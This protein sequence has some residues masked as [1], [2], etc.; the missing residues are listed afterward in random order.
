MTGCGHETKK[1]TGWLRK[2]TRFRCGGCDTSLWFYNLCFYKETFINALGQ[3]R[4]VID[5]SSDLWDLDGM[6]PLS[7]IKPD[8][9]INWG[10]GSRSKRPALASKIAQYIANWA[11]IDMNL[12]QMLGFILQS[13]ERAALAIYSSLNNRSAQLRMVKAAAEAALSRHDADIILAI[14]RVDVNPTMKYRDKMAHWVWGYS[15]DLPNDLLVSD[16]NSLRIDLSSALSSQTFVTKLKP[17]GLFVLTEKDLDN[18]LQR[19]SEVHRTL[20]ACP[21]SHSVFA[22]NLIPFAT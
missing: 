19:L 8:A 7:R 18:S 21:S 1:Q 10:I 16:P 15:D 3:T 22:A 20:G 17:N 14:I 9:R 11:E 4:R 5:M 6:Q 13:N 2:N 12:G